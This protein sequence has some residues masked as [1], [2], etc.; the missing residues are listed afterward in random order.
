MERIETKKNFTTL[1]SKPV[2]LQFVTLFFDYVLL[3]SMQDF[4]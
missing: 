4:L 2:A 3:P 1:L